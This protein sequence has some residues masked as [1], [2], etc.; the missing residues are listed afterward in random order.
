MSG[1]HPLVSII[2]PSFNQAAYLE[3]T[4]HS[5][6]SQDYAR[7]EYLVI[8][9]GSTDGSLDTIRRYTDRLAY[10][11]SEPD[12]GQA[13]AINKGLR[14]AK[15]EIVAWLNSDDL[16]YLPDA[17]TRAVRCLEGHPSA[18]M[19]YADGILVDTEG[20]LLDW[21]R[22]RP[23]TLLDLLSFQV[24]LQPTVFMR[25]AAVANVGLLRTSRQ[26]IFDHELWIRLAA[27]GTPIHVS[28]FWAVE[29]T[30]EQAKT[31]AQA[32]GFVEE[33]DRLLSDLAG[34]PMIAPVLAANRET[35]LAGVEV[36]AGKRLIDAGKPGPA[37][38]HFMRAGR[39]SPRAMLSVWYKV[40][41]AA[42]GALGLAGVF[43]AYRRI[44]RAA[45]HRKQ[46]IVVDPSGVHWSF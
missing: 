5:V 18:P 13:E 4:I 10:W 14:R 35:V 46:R 45:Q 30:H 42:G 19:V 31:V 25:K 40:V 20:A 7:L 11:V 21:H 6:L 16:Y 1:G 22:Y 26:L 12:A 37:L 27:L 15:G 32:A 24:L 43:L 33:A 3:D 29:R 38:R 17:V 9:G 8:D 2:T 36:F 23:Y 28:E 44:R 39:L 34:E 41:Q